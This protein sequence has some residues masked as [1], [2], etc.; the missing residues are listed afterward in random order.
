LNPLFENLPD[1]SEY[2]M[3]R[4]LLIKLAPSTSPLSAPLALLSSW[5]AAV[6]CRGCS[7]YLLLLKVYLPQFLFLNR[8]LE[9]VILLQSIS[10]SF[11]T[12]FWKTS[13]C[14]SPSGM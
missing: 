2:L 10:S 13:S 5:A 11:W 6:K 4:T 7:F 12:E 8:I 9:D 14:Y 3:E 1:T